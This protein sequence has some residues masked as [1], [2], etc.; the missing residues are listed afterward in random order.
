VLALE[1]PAVGALGLNL[2]DVRSRVAQDAQQPAHTRRDLSGRR[3][4]ERDEHGEV[5][6]D[7]LR[8]GLAAG[9]GVA[10]GG[11]D[12]VLVQPQGGFVFTVAS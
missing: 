7:E 4:I 10:L 5:V 1:V 9:S 11:A 8:D 3:L 2:A 12:E 6:L